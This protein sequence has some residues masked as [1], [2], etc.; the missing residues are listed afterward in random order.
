MAADSTPSS[1]TSVSQSVPDLQFPATSFLSDDTTP[2]TS[3]LPFFVQPI[4]SITGKHAP[5]IPVTVES[6]SV[7]LLLD[8][9]A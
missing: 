1:S 3:V 6:L 7:P 5:R 9:G 2:F 8:T 4:T